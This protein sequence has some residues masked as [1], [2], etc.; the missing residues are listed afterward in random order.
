VC[1]WGGGGE[2][3]KRGWGGYRGTVEGMWLALVLLP[4]CLA[5]G[6]SAAEMKGSCVV[7]PGGVQVGGERGT[8]Q[9]VCIG[10]KD[11]GVLHGEGV[12]L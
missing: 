7:R 11:E 2:G 6:P 1:V 3:G 9:D 10:E 4:A 12:G 5:L 8:D